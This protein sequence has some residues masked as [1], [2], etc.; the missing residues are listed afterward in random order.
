MENIDKRVDVKLVTM[1]GKKGPK[2]NTA[3]K[4]ITKPNFHNLI[5]FTE[6]FAAIQIRKTSDHHHLHF[7]LNRNVVM[8]KRIQQPRAL[9]MGNRITMTIT[10]KSQVLGGLSPTRK[11]NNN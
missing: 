1:W 3:A 9:H 2:Q 10:S 6:N 5:I 8:W 7:R 4:L 11:N